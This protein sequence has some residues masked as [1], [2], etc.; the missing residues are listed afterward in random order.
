MMA[1]VPPLVAVPVMEDITDVLLRVNSGDTGAAGKLFDC[2]YGEFRMLARRFFARESPGHTL[3]PTA[4]VHEAYFKL[5]DQT[6]VDWKNRSHFL[7]AG[8]AAMRRILVNHAIA[9]KRR[10]RGG[11]FTRIQ[12]DEHLLPAKEDADVLAVDDALKELATLNQ[13]H[14]KLVECRFFGGLT[15]DETAEVLGIS[16]GMARREWRACRAWLRGRLGA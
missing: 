9:K 13:R 11:E 14:A 12:I 8:A 2:V 4:L 5:V 3:Q 16:D 7:A 1:E 10:K 15:W 6:R